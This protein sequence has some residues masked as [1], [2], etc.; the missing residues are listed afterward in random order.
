M[1]RPFLPIRGFRIFASVAALALINSSCYGF[2]GGGFPSEI[3]SIFIEP[4]E[5]ETV[6]FELDQQ[7]FSKLR[8]R[9]PRALGVRQGSAQSADAILTGKILRYEDAA[10]NYRPG[11]AQQ[12]VQVLQHQVQITLELRIV[13]RKRNEIIWESTGLTGRGE[14]R[15]SDQRDEVGREQ[16]INN[17]VQQIIDGAQ[18]QW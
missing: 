12:T 7:I 2:G 17:I 3:R 15:P 13:N 1:P 10:Q 9:L 18:S 11:D 8:D 14:Y 6:Q 16:A 5:N 4:L